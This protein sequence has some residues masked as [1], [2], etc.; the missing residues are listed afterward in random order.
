MNDR[1]LLHLV[2]VITALSLVSN[3]FVLKEVRT[4]DAQAAAPGINPPANPSGMDLELDVRQGFNFASGR[5]TSFGYVD[6]LS[7][8]NEDLASDLTVT[9]PKHG[10]K[11]V[12]CVLKKISWD[13]AY[14]DP[15]DFNCRISAENRERI[16]DMV[17]MD[18]SAPT[19]KVEF[20]VH[21]FDHN[22][23]EYFKKFHTNGE[24]LDCSLNR[25]G[26]DLALNLA[27]DPSTDVTS[28]QNY[29]LSFSLMP[30]PMQ[31][32]HVGYDAMSTLV[33]Q[34]GEQRW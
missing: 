14:Y 2:L 20:T 26:S 21:A 13:A 7:L 24:R 30:E 33:R 22:A 25:Y 9:D 16:M 10:E 15:V 11:K 8:A 4:P 12:F 17:I 19:V 31:A 5:G 32:L 27:K 28:P 6:S 18:I 3:A 1:T 23:R 34:F 29:V